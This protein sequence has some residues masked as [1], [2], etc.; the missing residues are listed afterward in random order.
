MKTYINADLDQLNKAIAR[1]RNSKFY[2]EKLKDCSSNLECLED[3]EKFPLTY[4]AEVKDLKNFYKLLA[5]NPSEIFHVHS[6]TNNGLWALSKNDYYHVTDTKILGDLDTQDGICI[7][8]IPSVGWTGATPLVVLLQGSL[9]FI[10]LPP[11]RV[12]DFF[13]SFLENLE[14]KGIL[15]LPSTI[16]QLISLIKVKG[17]NPRNLG[18]DYVLLT[19]EAHSDFTAQYIGRELDVEIKD[20][21]G[22][23]ELLFIAA[24]ESNRLKVGPDSLVEIIDGEL[25]CTTYRKEAMPIVRYKTGDFV[26]VVGQEDD[27]TFYIKVKGRELERLDD[28]GS[29]VFPSDFEQVIFSVLSAPANY[30]I[31]KQENGLIVKVE[32]LDKYKGKI[33]DEL[34]R[35]FDIPCKVAMVDHGDL[36][37]IRGKAQRVVLE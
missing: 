13:I 33:N 24:G 25:V 14:V 6:S 35:C 3:I 36:P 29:G 28:E 1:S 23:A 20:L 15:G 30:L 4:P 16:T 9:R 19:G 10:C 37:K 32:G 26:E 11:S 21:Y 12:L 8:L 22:S 7:C 34:E 5:I 18:L 2:A 17:L 27:G 31:I